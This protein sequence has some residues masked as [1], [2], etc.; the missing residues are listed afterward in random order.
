MED[1]THCTTTTGNEGRR[2]ETISK[3]TTDKVAKVMDI[4]YRCSDPTYDGRGLDSVDEKLYSASKSLYSM[5]S[6]K[7]RNRNPNMPPIV[8]QPTVKIA[9]TKKPSYPIEKSTKQSQTTL[10]KNYGHPNLL[11]NPKFTL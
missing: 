6:E 7:L 11:S 2:D 4:Y 9:K 8:I 1:D 3:E 10:K 5:V